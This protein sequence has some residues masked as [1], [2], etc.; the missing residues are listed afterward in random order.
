[1]SKIYLIVVTTSTMLF[2]ACKQVPSASATTITNEDSITNEFVQE[3]NSN[4]IQS[5][6][7]SNTSPFVPTKQVAVQFLKKNKQIIFD[8]AGN[9]DKGY[10]NEFDNENT[11]VVTLK[12]YNSDSTL[13]AIA[14][15]DCLGNMTGQHLLVYLKNTGKKLQIDTIDTKFGME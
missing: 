2:T 12:D 5:S 8:K 7:S 4:T 10:C 1:M 15:F 11:I 6:Y 3:D 13:D 9:S 14:E